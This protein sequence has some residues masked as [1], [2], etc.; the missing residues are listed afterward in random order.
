MF[1]AVQ[2]LPEWFLG[3]RG[4]VRAHGEFEDADESAAL[5]HAQVGDR[6]RES[7]DDDDDGRRTKDLA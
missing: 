7:L 4:P 2:C 6:K 1:V 5:D 3:R